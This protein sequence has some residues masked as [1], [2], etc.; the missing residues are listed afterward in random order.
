MHAR[1]ARPALFPP[2][3]RPVRIH[4]LRR[5]PSCTDVP[6]PGA[7][8]VSQHCLCG[9]LFPQPLAG[10]G[11]RVFPPVCLS[12]VPPKRPDLR[13]PGPALCEKV[14]AEQFAVGEKTMYIYGSSVELNFRDTYTRGVSTMIK[15]QIGEK[16][17]T[18]YIRLERSEDPREGEKQR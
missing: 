6:Y 9:L 1:W 8:E 10:W 12:D 2:V 15:C 16:N 13:K 11:S 4:F 14:V 5:P 17:R 18:E 7:S 3:P